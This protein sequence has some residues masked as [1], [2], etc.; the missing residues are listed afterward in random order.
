MT[1]TRRDFLKHA[2]LIAAGTTLSSSVPASLFAETADKP[3][4]KISLAEWSLHRT[5]HSGQLSNLDFPAKAK[6]DFGI[7]AVEYVNVFF[8]DKAND[9]GYLAELKKRCEDN[10]VRSLIIMVD[11]E[12]ELANTDTSLRNKSVEN[13]YKW[14]DAA[15]FLG[16]HSIRVNCAGQGSPDSVSLAGIDGLRKLSEYGKQADVNV[17]VENHGGYSSNGQW[18]SG[19][20]RSVG[21]PNCGTLPDFGNFS[22]GSDP[23]YDR[24][25]GIEELMPFAKGVSAKVFDMDADGNCVETDYVKMMKIVKASGYRG[26]VGVEYEASRFS[27]D[28]GIRRTKLLLEKVAASM[29][30]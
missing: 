2:G 9:K 21:M 1:S 6:R 17:I 5:L 8:A 20:I 22:R 30:D 14:V 26:Y 13:H 18:L 28:E 15:K 19:V 10:G 12:G 4:F 23:W 7:D 24:Y 25:K 3:F 29:M 16:C 11:G 27:E